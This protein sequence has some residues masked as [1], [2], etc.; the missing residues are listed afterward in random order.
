VPAPAPVPSAALAFAGVPRRLG[1]G[2]SDVRPEKT[3][4]A[5]PVPRAATPDRCL[6]P[7]RPRH[8]LLLHSLGAAAP[9][10][11]APVEDGAADVE[12]TG[13]TRADQTIRAVR[14][15]TVAPEATT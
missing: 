5:A 8:P 15:G 4:G 6:R 2:S 3:M 9:A 14:A 7:P 10:T 13:P 1:A 12:G 11:T